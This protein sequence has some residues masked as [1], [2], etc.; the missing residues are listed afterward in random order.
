MK[1]DYTHLILVLD[2]SGSMAGLQKATIEGINSLV[3]NQKKQPGTIT[4]AMYT[5]DHAVHEVK[6]FETLTTQNY[7][8]MGST[9]L[10]DAVCT[11][12]DNEGVR[13]TNL[14]ENDRPDKVVVVIDTDGEENASTQFT[15]EDMKKRINLQQG[16]YQWEFVFLGA[17]I[18]AF[19]AGSSFGILARSTYQYQP[20]A[21]SVFVKYSAV[22][23]SL[24]SYRSGASASVDLSKP[25]A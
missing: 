25:T 1:Q 6:E 18:D 9:A 7:V 13:L 22:N 3:D 24:T 8:P 4:T 15:L 23:A 21:N 16:S 19:A 12:I 10:I 2:K 11:A 14:N 20:D 17:N 5:F